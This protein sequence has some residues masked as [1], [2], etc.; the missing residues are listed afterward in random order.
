[1]A[2]YEES[3]STTEDVRRPSRHRIDMFGLLVGLA[4]LLVSANILTDGAFPPEGL[5]GKWVLVGAAGLIGVVM[6]LAS[7][8]RKP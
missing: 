3:T 8:R 6:L 5:S 4:A 1:M 2:E 7:L